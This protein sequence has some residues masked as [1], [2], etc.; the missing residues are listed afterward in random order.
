MVFFTIC[1][2]KAA[3]M[4]LKCHLMV[5]NEGTTTPTQDDMSDE[6]VTTSE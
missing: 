2:Y 4:S 5:L 1:Q 3:V 6:A